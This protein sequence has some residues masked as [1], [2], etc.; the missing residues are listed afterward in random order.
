[1]PCGISVPQPGIEPMPPALEAGNLNH[2]ITREV[3]CWHSERRPFLSS[4]LEAGRG[5]G[6]RQ[7]RCI[8]LSAV[9]GL[10]ASRLE[11]RDGVGGWGAG[12]GDT[13]GLCSK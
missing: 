4:V 7:P 10:P 3:L 1:M 13:A 5:L 11:G 2:W 6:R 9:P 12:A 8:V